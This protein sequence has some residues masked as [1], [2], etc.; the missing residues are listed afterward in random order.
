MDIT[1]THLYDF[2]VL[3]LYST[4]EIEFM[5]SNQHKNV[6]FHW[7]LIRPQYNIYSDTALSRV[8]YLRY[9]TRY[10]L[11]LPRNMLQVTI[12]TLLPLKS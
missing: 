11:I 3:Y 9:C 6:Y 5:Q 2:P 1:H 10:P 7:L 8:Q 4:V 12:D